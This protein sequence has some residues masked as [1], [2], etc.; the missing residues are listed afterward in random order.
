MANQN[1]RQEDRNQQEN[2][3]GGFLNQVGETI[4]NMV[5][6]LTGDNQNN[7]NQQGER[8]NQKNRS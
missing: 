3:Q 2:N 5:D 1:K 7:N 8:N 6:T 4:E